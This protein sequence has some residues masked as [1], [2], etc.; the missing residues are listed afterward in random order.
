MST[1]NRETQTTVDKDVCLDN[2]LVLSDGE[3]QINLDLM[4]RIKS[5]EKECQTIFIDH[6]KLKTENKATQVQLDIIRKV[7]INN[8]KTQTPLH[9]ANFQVEDKAIQV[10]M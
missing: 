10:K 1:E 3:I 8:V 9:L 7:K 6:K 5:H 4:K 2:I